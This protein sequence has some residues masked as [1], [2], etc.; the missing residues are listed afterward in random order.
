[1]RHLLFVDEQRIHGAV[2]VHIL[3]AIYLFTLLSV[4]CN[5][6]FLPSVEYICEDLTIP[7]VYFIY[8]LLPT[9]M[10]TI[11]IFSHLCLQNYIYKRVRMRRWN[12]KI[13]SVCV[14]GCCSSY[15]YGHCYNDTG[16]FHQCHQYIHYR[17]RHWFRCNHWVIDVQYA[18]CCGCCI[19]CRTQPRPIRLVANHT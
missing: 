14:S 12:N 6:Y 9:H 15:I 17:I 16:I 10:K 8:S 1:M 3:I 4:V 19:D 7:K 5:D 11:C 2:I 18:G 13:C